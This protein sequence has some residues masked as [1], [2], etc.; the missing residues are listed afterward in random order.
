MLRHPVKLTPENGKLLVAFPDL[1]NIHTRGDDE[2][3]AL[4]RAVDALETMLMA[5]IEDKKE[6]PEP[7]PIR[8]RARFV[9]LL[10]LT[11]AKI[12]LEMKSSRVGK[13]ELARR[14]NC[15]LHRSIACSTWVID[16]VS[17]DWT[18][19][20]PLSGSASPVRSRTR[21]GFN[22]VHFRAASRCFPE[23]RFGDPV[24]RIP[25]GKGIYR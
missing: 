10:V 12:D 17:I 16:P 23:V 2:P 9:A 11:E 1:P 14:L 22:T 3:E 25:G 5:M 8:R 18:R 13:G 15:H 7:R 19:H 20:S 4:A 24:L 21:P 6:V